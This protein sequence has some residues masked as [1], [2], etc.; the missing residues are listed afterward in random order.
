MYCKCG[1]GRVT[2]LASKTLNGRGWVKGQHLDFIHNHH[3]SRIRKSKRYRVVHMG[4]D[5]PCWLWNLAL[6]D[7]GY[8]QLR[9][10][11]KAYK[12]HRWYWEQQN[13]PVPDGLELDHLCR[14]RACVNPDHL[15]PVTRLENMK[16]AK[17]FRSGDASSH[18][19]SNTE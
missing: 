8:G 10:M 18:R 11:K 4:H 6:T 16:R 17:P 12:A 1:C 15:E 5:T 2:K 7:G 9:F 3:T 14:N 13:G 19:R